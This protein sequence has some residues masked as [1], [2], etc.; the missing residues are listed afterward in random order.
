MIDDL[1]AL[2]IFAETVRLKSFRQAARALGLSPSVVSYH[3]TQLEQ[4][5]GTALLYRS[6]RKLSLTSDGEQLYHHARAML[7]IARRGL[8]DVVADGDDLSGQL[9]LTLPSFLARAPISTSLAHFSRQFPNLAMQI[10]YTDVRQDVVGEGIDL[11]IRAG[12]LPDNSLRARKIGEIERRL[13]CTPQYLND[14]IRPLVPETLNDWDWILLEMLPAKRMLVHP[15]GKTCLLQCDGRL[16]V[17]SVEA[18][19]H[20]CRQGL[21]LCTPPA[22]MVNADL[23]SKQLVE[24]MQPWKVQPIPLYAVWPGNELM[25]RNTRH[26]V[27]FLVSN[28]SGVMS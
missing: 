9:K 4:R 27:D 6:T 18:M 15:D 16:T 26:L 23:S 24:I 13:V 12:G 17:D 11:A 28:E 8:S 25:N 19:A 22:Y 14:R 7:E 3:V 2:A 5:V 1:R 20:F 21:G 10:R